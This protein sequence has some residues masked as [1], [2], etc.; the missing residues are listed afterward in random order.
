MLIN[1]PKCKCG[2]KLK[3]FRVEDW[4][5]SIF[6]GYI[7]EYHTMGCPKCEMCYDVDITVTIVDDIPTIVS[8]KEQEDT[9]NYVNDFDVGYSY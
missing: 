1:Y 6:D 3:D 2:E 8:I 5:G 7:T 9:E 4:E